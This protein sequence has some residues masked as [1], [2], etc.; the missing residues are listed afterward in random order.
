MAA[1]EV[2]ALS[3]AYLTRVSANGAI[4]AIRRQA[5]TAFVDDQALLAPVAAL[6]VTAADVA[7]FTVQHNAG[8][9]WGRRPGA[10]DRL[11]RFNDLDD[12]KR[13]C[14]RW[15]RTGCI[16]SITE[17]TSGAC[18]VRIDIDGEWSPGR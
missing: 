10:L 18:W 5:A 16:Q 14:D 17:V 11:E 6:L 13:A 7:P 1:G 15:R 3:G 2:I 8:R 9:S 4:E 12:A